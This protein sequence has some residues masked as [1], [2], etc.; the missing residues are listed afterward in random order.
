MENVWY[1]GIVCG[2]LQKGRTF[3]YPTANMSAVHPSLPCSSG[4][5]AARVRV[6]LQE[7]AAM[8]YVGTRP[9]LAMTSPTVEI[10]LLDYAGDLY[11]MELAFMVVG[12]VREERRFASEKELVSQISED[13]KCI[14][15]ML[16]LEE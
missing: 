11:G 3:G 13:E 12:K 6:D 8:L 2:G 15:Q 7:Y 10:H 16:S 9:T 4:V 14:R 5:Y 1:K